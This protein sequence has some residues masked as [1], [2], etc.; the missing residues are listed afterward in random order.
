MGCQKP[1]SETISRIFEFCDEGFMYRVLCRDRF[2]S[3]RSRH[4]ARGHVG[5][6]LFWNRSQAGE[7][8]V[9]AFEFDVDALRGHRDRVDRPGVARRRAGHDEAAD[10][11]V[12]GAGGLHD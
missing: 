1:A 9:R 2:P 4:D 6:G 7:G 12:V 11:D 8:W 10:C 3:D 5:R